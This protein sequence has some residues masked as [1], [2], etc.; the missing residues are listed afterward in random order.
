MKIK[1]LFR[2]L[3]FI[4][5]LFPFIA[6]GGGVLA[7]AGETTPQW[8]QRITTMAEIDE[9]GVYLIGA[10]CPFD[11]QF[12]LMSSTIAKKN[13]CKAISFCKSNELKDIIDCDD[14]AC[15]W[16]LDTVG[17]SGWIIREYTGGKSLYSEKGTHL[18]PNEKNYTVWSIITN[19]NGFFITSSD[20]SHYLSFSHWGGSDDRFGNYISFD[21]NELILYKLITDDAGDVDA[22][23]TLMKDGASVAISSKSALATAD[24][25][26][27]SID[28]YLLQDGTVAV[29]DR[30]GEWTYESRGD[31]GFVLR[32]KE[33]KY[34]G[35]D[36]QVSDKE[37]LWCVNNG[38]IITDEAAGAGIPRTLC[39]DG[40]FKLVSLDSLKIERRVKLREA[41]RPDSTMADGNKVL[42]GGWSKARIANVSWQDVRS[43]DLTNLSLPVTGLQDF[44]N[45]PTD[46]NTIIYI[47]GESA[48]LVPQTENFVV[49][50]G[51]QGDTLLTATVLRDRQPLHVMRDIAYSAGQ[52]TYQR[53]LQNDT[54]WNTLYLPFEAKVSQGFSLCQFKSLDS[55]I[56]TFEATNLIAAYTPVLLRRN[57]ATADTTFCAVA[58]AGGTL[59]SSPAEQE[60]PFIGT[61]AQLDFDETYSSACIFLLNE[62]GDAFVRTGE[63]CRLSPFRAYISY[64]SSANA[65]RLHFGEELT[66]IVSPVSLCEDTVLRPCFDISGRLIAP[67]MSRKA[68]QQ[69]PRGIYIY[70]GQTIITK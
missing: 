58:S 49:A 53:E 55:N 37:N 17:N 33:G 47:R 63:N 56:L 29:D 6:K 65:L 66:N 31:N 20:E 48:N 3:V 7:V 54:A 67:L 16:C 39:Y 35:Y 25:S 64:T 15:L 13:W 10:N 59:Y 14:N 52:L 69:L 18:L 43:L 12:Y 41:L 62:E 2:F 30:V 45:R 46:A 70:N 1:S 68:V 44:K 51:E 22:R 11:E 8:F 34:L 42:S 9:G 40:G 4:T 61:L 21:S 60:F 36:L 5:F 57:V 27:V 50:Q 23:A 19:K 38:R 26:A 24:L 32:N 28:D